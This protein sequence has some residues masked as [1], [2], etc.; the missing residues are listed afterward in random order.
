MIY[1]ILLGIVLVVAMFAQGYIGRTIRITKKIKS[2]YGK[3]GADVAREILSKRN[4]KNIKI[5]RDNG[6]IADHY[7]PR[8]K[9]IILSSKVYDGKSLAALGIAAHECGH[10]LQNHDGYRFLRFRNF[11]TPLLSLASSVGFILILVGLII[12]D[13]D[14]IP[15]GVLIEF[16][17]FIFNVLSLLAEKDASSRGI[18]QLFKYNIVKEKE[19]RYTRK[20]LR[21]SSL[22]Y[23]AGQISPLLQIYRLVVVTLKNK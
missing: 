6:L 17:V 11:I 3:T 10:A 14:F 20:I 2:S 19:Y 4:A 7:D 5:V 13:P 23:V 21:A 9:T 1:Y 18:Q 8:T 15:V 16:S 12:P 22:V